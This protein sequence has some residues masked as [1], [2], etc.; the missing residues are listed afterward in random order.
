MPYQSVCRLLQLSLI[1]VVLE[2]ISCGNIVYMISVA[3]DS[4]IMTLHVIITCYNQSKVKSHEHWQQML[5]LCTWPINFDLRMSVWW[6]TLGLC[7]PLQSLGCKC[8][9]LTSCHSDA[10][11]KDKLVYVNVLLS[12]VLQFRYSW[13]RLT[14]GK[15]QPYVWP[16][17]MILWWP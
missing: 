8:D 1:F 16:Q 13:H 2:E 7:F 14:L 10:N 4:T 5:K 12:V 3:G 17:Y 6:V 15:L 11:L 9:L